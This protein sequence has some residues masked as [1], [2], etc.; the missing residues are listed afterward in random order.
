[1][2][3][4]IGKIPHERGPTETS[5]LLSQQNQEHGTMVVAPLPNGDGSGDAEA[6]GRV[7]GNTTINGV[8]VAEE[9]S[10]GKLLAIMG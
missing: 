8:V 1:M 7:D 6:N 5:P 3:Y 4:T 2:P 10:T 9:P